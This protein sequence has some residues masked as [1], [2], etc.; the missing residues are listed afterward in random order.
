MTLRSDYWGQ[1]PHIALPMVG[2]F[3]QRSLRSRM[4]DANVRFVEQKETGLFEALGWTIRGW[5]QRWFGP[6]AKPE[7]SP[8]LAT[9]AP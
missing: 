3:F 4:I 9:V 6:A 7:A 1:G 2:D 8:E 5:Y